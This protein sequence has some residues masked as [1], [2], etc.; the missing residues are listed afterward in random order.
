MKKIQALV[1]L[2]YVKQRSSKKYC[3]SGVV[4]ELTEDG[5]QEAVE[6]KER[7]MQN[8]G[9]KLIPLRQLVSRSVSSCYA[10][11][12]VVIDFREGGGPSNNLHKFCN[13]LDC[14]RVPF[15]VRELKIS[16]YVFFYGEYIAPY[17][18]ERKSLV[19]VAN[20]LA[21]SRWENQKT[22]MKK[23]R[24]VLGSSCKLYYIIEGD[25]ERM[26]KVHGGYVGRAEWKKVNTGAYC[27]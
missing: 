18:V 27:K 17:F 5:R 22:N 26:D 21:D 7:M 11:L 1:R 8:A 4:F 2:G 13:H 23:A 25:P 24:I 10:N 20:S 19:D 15:V 3:Q 14:R 12:T 6:M 9:R 16:D